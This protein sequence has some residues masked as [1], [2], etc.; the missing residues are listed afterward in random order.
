MREKRCTVR[1]GFY[2]LI[3]IT[4]SSCSQHYFEG[5]ILYNYQYLDK[6]GKDITD[7]MKEVGGAEQHYFI[8]ARNYKSKNE[9]NQLTQLYNSAT[10]QYYF[11]VGLEL[12]MVDAAKEFPEKNESKPLKGKQAILDIPCRSLQVISEVGVTTYFYSK[13]IKVDPGPFSKHRFGNWNNYL[14]MTKGALPLKFIVAFERYTLTATAVKITPM[15]L[16]D[17]GFEVK[18]ALEK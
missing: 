8:N 6:E 1:V 13:K 15:K 11:N 12:Q 18:L 16:S 14:S 9:K 10:N 17:A 3:A 2:L 5:K 4:C 7:R